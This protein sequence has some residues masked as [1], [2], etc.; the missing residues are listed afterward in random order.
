[1]VA[2]YGVS[3]QTVRHALSILENEGLIIRRQGSG[4]YVTEHRQGSQICPTMDKT[5]TFI[6]TYISDYV[7]P[8]IIRGAEEV[9]TGSGYTLKISQTQNRVELERKLLVLALKVYRRSMIIEGTKTA[10]PNP[11]I[12]L[13]KNSNQQGYRWFCQRLLSGA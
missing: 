5:I 10:F 11:N 12:A 3:R 8:S 7:F 9:L 6:S 4:I 13:Y 2:R 1:M